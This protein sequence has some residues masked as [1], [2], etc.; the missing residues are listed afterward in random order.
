M[1]IKELKEQIENKPV[2][3]QLKTIAEIF[4]RQGCIHFKFRN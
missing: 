2:E 4:P 1:E 3:D